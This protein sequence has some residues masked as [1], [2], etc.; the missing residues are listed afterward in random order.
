MGW[1]IDSSDRRFRGVWLTVLVI[2][3][4]VA[5]I[6][7]KPITAILFAQAANGLLLPVVAIF[8]LIVMNRSDLL[9]Q[10]S[11][12]LAANAIASLV[13]VI[14]TALGLFKLAT[15]FFA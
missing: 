11:N 7:T 3:T 9:E 8:L 4:L 10:H 15:V 13:V 14:V 1:P 6:G 12:S 5:A 2:G